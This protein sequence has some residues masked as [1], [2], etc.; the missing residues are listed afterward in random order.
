MTRPSEIF[1]GKNSSLKSIFNAMSSLKTGVEGMGGWEKRFYERERR[2]NNLKTGCAVCGS[3]EDHGVMSNFTHQYDNGVDI[4]ATSDFSFLA[5][6]ISLARKEERAEI[7]E[8]LYEMVFEQEDPDKA[9][10]YLNWDDAKEFLS[11]PSK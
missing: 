9:R 3:P 11:N 8:K 10:L 5:N 2:K 7:I 1:E 4:R 6:E